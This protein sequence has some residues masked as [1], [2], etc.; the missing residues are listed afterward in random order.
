MFGGV[1]KTYNTFQFLGLLLC[2]EGQRQKRD[3]CRGAPL[4]LLVAR[5]QR[6]KVTW[7]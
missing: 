5:R 7:G 1:L 3:R 6:G 2:E 4:F